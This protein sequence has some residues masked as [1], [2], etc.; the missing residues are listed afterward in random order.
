M[1]SAAGLLFQ[2]SNVDILPSEYALR[3]RAVV[4]LRCLGYY[5][6]GK[7]ASVLDHRSNAVWRL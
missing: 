1:Q 4:T 7:E 5:R 6:Y 2:Q 3:W